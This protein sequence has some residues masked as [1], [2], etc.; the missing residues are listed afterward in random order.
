MCATRGRALLDLHRRA[1]SSGQGV[2]APAQVK[3][4]MTIRRQSISIIFSGHDSA[5]HE[6]VC[7]G[8]PL[9]DPADDSH[10]RTWRGG[11]ADSQTS[12]LAC[13]S[14]DVHSAIVALV[15][16]I[17]VPA[18]NVTK[19]EELTAQ[20]RA[21]WPEL[22]RAIGSSSSCWTSRSTASSIQLRRRPSNAFCWIVRSRRA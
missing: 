6:C 12:S 10:C 11:T 19:H 9:V 16:E 15:R 14:A 18:S 7:R 2:E 17:F 4:V 8:P 1:A 5:R 13:S 20:L 22:M 3:P 21:E